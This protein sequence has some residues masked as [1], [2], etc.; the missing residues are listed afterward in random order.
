MAIVKTFHGLRPR[1][2]AAAEV[3]SLPYDVFSREEA[4]EAVKGHPLSF[5]NIDRPETQFGPD[6]DMYSDAAYEKAKELLAK[7]TEEGVF[8][9]EEKASFYVYEQTAETGTPEGQKAHSQTGIAVCVS[10]D[11]YLKGVVKEHESTREDKA[12]DRIRHVEVCEA[13]TGPI[14]LT[15]RR[16]PELTE[17]TD[18]VKEQEPLYDFCS[19]DGT[20]QRMWRV[21]SEADTG[22]IAELFA[23]VPEVYIADGHHRA[24]SAVKV[25]LK[26]REKNP[27]YTGK[28]EF[29]YILSVL[30]PAEDL[31]ILPYNRFVKDLNG[32]SAEDFLLELDAHFR[33]RDFGEEPVLPDA[34]GIFGMYLG[35]HWYELIADEDV[36]SEDA[37]DGLDVSILQNTTLG[38]VLGINDPRTE[39]RISF[40]GG[41]RGPKELERLVDAAD[42]ARGA[43]G[44]GPAAGTAVAFTLY[45]TQIEELFRVADEGRLMPPK[46]TWFEPKLMSGLLI[47]QI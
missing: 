7:E 45:P 12:Q 21:D 39:S 19:S 35:G 9:R 37:V 31:M 47:H 41:I 17:I 15:Y 20:R 1:K 23:A 18:R 5:L 27:E 40:V 16:V 22:R 33:L 32:L 42:E 2:D 4:R 11:D 44:K 3:A 34:K 36:M 28:E 26:K 46:S 38:R 13:Q 30:F 8:I 14:F 24:A 43:K 6:F 29:N 10:V 25:A